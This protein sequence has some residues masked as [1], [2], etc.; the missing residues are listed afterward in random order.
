MSQQTQ[1]THEETHQETHE[2]AHEETHQETDQLYIIDIRE[3][4]EILE[5][6][7]ITTEK[8]STVICCIPMKFIRWNISF[9][10][11]LTNNGIVYIICR[12]SNRSNTIK[13][14]Y[15]KDN[16]KVISIQGGLEELKQNDKLQKTLE[17]KVQTN[18][19]LNIFQKFGIQQY[20]QILFSI[21]LSITLLL[22][23][24]RVKPIYI[25]CWLV[26]IILFIIYQLVTKSCI[27]SQIINKITDNY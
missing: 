6:R 2:E 27:L 11:H 8:S 17:I 4:H 1:E 7:I 3:E 19:D 14:K 13:N 22:L 26:F 10:N 5:E 18:I 20:M 24:L 25:I 23:I 9:I 12:S 16:Q 15:F 21:L